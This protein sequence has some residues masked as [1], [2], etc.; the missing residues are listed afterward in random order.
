MLYIWS[1]LMLYICTNQTMWEAIR[2]G[3]L[4][5][6]GGIRQGFLRLSGS[7][8]QGVFGT[9]RLHPTRCFGAIRQ[10]PT[11]CFVA[12]DNVFHLAFRHGPTSS[13]SYFRKRNPTRCPCKIKNNGR[14]ACTCIE[15]PYGVPLDVMIRI[16]PQA[17]DAQ[18]L[19]V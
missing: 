9:S 1:L 10:G 2:Q 14:I 16:F 17:K 18:S 3:V 19:S 8:R 13:V 7:T 5:L 15:M 12:S 11:S 4:E 6:S